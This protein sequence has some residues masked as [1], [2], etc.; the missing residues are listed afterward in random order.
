[1]QI[2]ERPTAASVLKQLRRWLSDYN[3][4]HPH[5]A[6]GMRSPRAFRGAQLM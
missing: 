5:R 2:H 6:L 3:R 1:M 4:H